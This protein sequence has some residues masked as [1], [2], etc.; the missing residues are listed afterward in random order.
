[1]Y[2]S[3]RQRI[4]R[5]LCESHMLS[6]A[7][8]H[9][10]FL[11]MSAVTA[12]PLATSAI[13][14][15]L[16]ACRGDGPLEC[17]DLRTEACA[18][19]AAFL[20]RAETNVSSYYNPSYRGSLPISLLR[21]GHQQATR[22]LLMLLG[23]KPPIAERQL[24]EWTSVQSIIL[25]G[26]EMLPLM[27]FWLEQT[28]PSE[29]WENFSLGSNLDNLYQY[30]ELDEIETGSTRPIPSNIFDRIRDKIKTAALLSCGLPWIWFSVV[31]ERPD[32]LRVLL[33][34]GRNPKIGYSFN[35]GYQA[36]RQAP[37]PV[38]GLGL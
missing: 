31:F 18:C 20:A 30:R 4:F 25:G 33:E 10:L 28:I 9:I 38:V 8:V 35:T 3:F 36:S 14:H 11:F 7:T 2:K 24:L 1:M 22:Q 34:N 21:L 13:L 32:I 15:K 37:P 27:Q 29:E 5:M 26:P 12:A 16:E 6:F 19:A 17:D 23:L